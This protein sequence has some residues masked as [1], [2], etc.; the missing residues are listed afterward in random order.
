MYDLLDT[1][2][3]DLSYKRK[4]LTPLN[5]KEDKEHY[6]IELIAPKRSKKDFNL[7]VTDSL[8][9]IELQK[10]KESDIYLYSEWYDY[11]QTR[12]VRLPKD[13]DDT[14]ISA[15][16]KGGVLTIKIPKSEK[17]KPKSTTVT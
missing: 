1:L 14:N 13:A 3:S 8:L 10:T 4:R 11:T 16:Y 15:K 9:T 6:E 17:F 7:K 5:V 12:H 2:T